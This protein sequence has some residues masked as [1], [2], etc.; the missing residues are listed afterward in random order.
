V[1]ACIKIDILWLD[2][3]VG[4]ALGMKIVDSGD[5]LPEATFGLACGHTTLLDC[6]IQVTAW[7]V[8][9]HLAPALLV[10]LDKVDSLNNVDVV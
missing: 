9:H 2:V 8:F 6:Y 1:P 3:S 7:T 10:V 5:K 4:Y